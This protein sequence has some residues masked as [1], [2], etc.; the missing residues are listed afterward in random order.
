[1]NSPIFSISPFYAAADK[2]LGHAAHRVLT[3][4]CGFADPEGLCFPSRKVLC[5]LTG[6]ENSNLSKYINTLCR[7]GYL[8][9]VNA[10]GNRYKIIGFKDKQW[11]MVD[12]GNYY[13][14]ENQQHGNSYHENISCGND[15]HVDGNSYHADGNDYHKTGNSVVMITNITDQKINRPM[16]QTNKQT[17]APVSSVPVEGSP[18]LPEPAPTP[19]TAKPKRKA[20]TSKNSPTPLPENFSISDAV[21]Q[22][23]NRKGFSQDYLDANFEKFVNYVE[24]KGKTYVNWDRAL[25][26]AISDNWAKFNIQ[27]INST[28]PFN[29][30]GYNG[31]RK[32][33]IADDNAR[34]AA[35][36]RNLA[37][38]AAQR[39]QSASAPQTE[40][41]RRAVFNF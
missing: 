14:N 28:Q 22:W 11:P 38:Q 26:D 31:Y 32:Y 35:L 2:N 19:I 18:L 30:G 16:E 4:L 20:S 8:E 23:A 36:A 5:G 37:E 33:T 24:K 15:Y 25:M 6:I 12:C 1:M 41:Q 7:K 17:S 34:E 10:A 21:K 40:S 27:P 39:N 13:H 9:K 29:A 3:L